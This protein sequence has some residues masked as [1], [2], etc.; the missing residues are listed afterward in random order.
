MFH[1]TQAAKLFNQEFHGVLKCC[2]LQCI[3]IFSAGKKVVT[4]KG[5]SRALRLRVLPVDFPTRQVFYA[6]CQ[7]GSDVEHS[8]VCI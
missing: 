6:H 5:A 8:G 2:L 1:A 3:S 7:P 4:P